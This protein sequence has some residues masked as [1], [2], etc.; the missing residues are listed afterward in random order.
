MQG[1]AEQGN[2]GGGGRKPFMVKKQDKR[3]NYE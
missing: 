2:T 3:E 1:R